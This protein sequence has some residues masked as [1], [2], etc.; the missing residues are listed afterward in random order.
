MVLVATR[1]AMIRFLHFID[2]DIDFNYT[3]YHYETLNRTLLAR[4]SFGMQPT[5]IRECSPANG[6]QHTDPITKHYLKPDHNP[7]HC[8]YHSNSHGN[9]H[10]DQHVFP[11]S[12]SYTDR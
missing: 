9:P 3:I 1:K 11:H 2:S 8:D 5:C 4:F 6:D 10:T 12:I 7:Y